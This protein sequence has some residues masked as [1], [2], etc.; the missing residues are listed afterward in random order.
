MTTEERKEQALR[1]IDKQY[2]RLEELT[3]SAYSLD[4][5]A[6]ADNLM[7]KME[8][9]RD[10]TANVLDQYISSRKAARLREIT[11]WISPSS[12]LEG[13]MDH[14][15]LLQNFLT[16][17]Q[18][19]IEEDADLF[20]AINSSQKITTGSEI[21][22]KYVQ[23]SKNIFIVHGHDEINLYKL[24][25]IIKNHFH[26][27]PIVL[28]DQPGKSRTLIE[29]LEQEGSDVNYAFVLYTP[30]DI[31]ELANG[32]YAQARPN[33][34]F[35]LGWFFGRLG[36]SKTC[37]LF[38]KGTKIHTDLEGVNRIEFNESVEEK[39]I[40]IERELKAAG[41]IKPT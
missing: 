15:I 35:E 3:S 14:I 2:K 32:K 27:N 12:I 29:K 7:M 1:V 21:N 11:V 18:K 26:L 36:R 38:K 6:D 28:K 31:V 19:E 30:D 13:I 9:W 40:E 25:N 20:F 16:D 41:I 5:T 39:I 34:I 17:L 33:V 23:T 22:R 8:N 37:I 10:D 24:E 4:S